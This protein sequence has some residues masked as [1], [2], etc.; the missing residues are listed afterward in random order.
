MAERRRDNERIDK[1]ISTTRTTVR[2]IEAQGGRGK[3]RR[4]AD[5]PVPLLVAMRWAIRDSTLIMRFAEGAMNI[6]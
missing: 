3:R 6:S 4:E 1:M 2:K 5:R